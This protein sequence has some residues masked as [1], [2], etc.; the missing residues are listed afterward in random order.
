MQSIIKVFFLFSLFLFSSNLFA[1]TIAFDKFK[2]GSLDQWVGAGYT[3]YND[4][5]MYID[6]DETATKQ[7]NFGT[8]YANQE[9]SITFRFYVPDSWEKDGKYK[10]R[11]RVY[12][13]G[14]LVKSY[15]NGG[16]TKTKTILTTANAGGSITL[17]FKPDSTAN[18][19][20]AAVD[21]VKITGT[22]ISGPPVIAPTSFSLNKNSANNTTV[23]TA[24]TSP[25]A[26]AYSI[27][28]GNTD[29]IFSIDNNGL[30]KVIDNTNLTNTLATSYTLR[31][32]ASN[33]SGSD[34]GDII[35]NIVTTAII[36]TNL[37]DFSIRNP[38]RT[39]NIKGNIK[40][41][42]NSVL[43]YKVNGVCTER[44]RPNNETTLSYIKTSSG[45][46]NSSQAE[47][48]D[49]PINAK[50]LW[51]GFY[52][53]GYTNES[54]T[55]MKND[56]QNNA[57]YLIEP[58]GDRLTILPNNIDLFQWNGYTYSTYSELPQL[59]GMTGG[60]INGYWTG[61]NIKA[62]EG[63]DTSLGYFGAWTLV[64]IYEEASESLKN[65]SVFDGY[66][67]VS[68][69]STYKNIY[70]PVTGFLTPTTGNIASSLSVFAGEGDSS[71]RGDKLYVDN[72]DISHKDS[73]GTSNAFHSGTTGFN[74][75]PTLINHFGIDI[76]NYDIG[77]TGFD[78]IQHSQQSSTIHLT[79]A[80]DAYF[81][82]MV[83][84]TT[85][86]F[87]PRVCY[88]QSFLDASGA[89]LS[90]INI[91]D[92]I[93]VYT[94][95]SNM[96]KDATDGNLESADKVEITM[97]L[98]SD[99]LEYITDSTSVKNIGDAAYNST[100]KDAAGTS[101]VDIADFFSDTNTSKWR[102]GTGAT[103]VLGGLLLPNATGV[104][105]GKA[106]IKFK[107]KILKDG[108]ISVN[109]IYKVSY[110]NPQ[111][112]IRFGDE[113]PINIGVCADINTS[114]GVAGLLGAFNVVNENGGGSAYDDATNA[115][116]WLP[117]QVAGRS[118]NV[119]LLSLNNTGNALQGYTGDVDV[120]LIQTPNYASCGNDNSC[121]QTLCDNQ[122]T[123]S[124]G[125]TVTFTGEQSK[126]LSFVYTNAYQNVSFKMTYNNGAKNACSLD[127][128][129][130][131]PDRFLLSAP[132][133][134]DIEL[135]T[136]AQNYN[137]SL[138]AA[139]NTPSVSA[140]TGYTIATVDST[141][142][143]LNKTMYLK[144]G[145]I[146]AGNTL[147]GNLAFSAT[148]FS[149]TDGTASNVVGLSF[150]DVG[151]VNI[152][153]IDKTWAQVDIANSDTAQDCSMTGAYVCGGADAIFIPSS[154]S[155]SGVSLH[156]SDNTNFTYLSNDLNM[157][158]H[159]ELS[160]NAKN[161]LNA[162]TQNF[163]AS[164]WENP[165]D[166][167]FTVPVV[168]GMVINKDEVDETLN[169]SFA[170]GS[171]SILWSETNSS[172]KLMFNYNRDVNTV[173]N[174]FD[175]TGANVTLTASSLYTAPT[176]GT[177][178]TVSGTAPASLKATFLYGRTHEP[179]YRY[180]GANGVAFI[181]YESY[182]G[183]GCDKTLL[184]NGINSTTTDDPRWFINTNHLITSGSAGVVTQ[185]GANNVASTV[186]SAAPNTSVTLTYNTNRGYPY[187]A[188]MEN[189]ASSW[190]LYNKYNAGAT[191]NEF[192]IEFVNNVN[193]WAGEHETN[194][195][196]NVN[197]SSKTNR[198]TMW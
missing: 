15:S 74:V 55:T 12:I 68:S 143:D 184:P 75:N 187:K 3:Y 85:D 102:V 99:N 120:A 128:F 47:I 162:T 98:D 64:I 45:Y 35:I 179:R 122:V 181:Y 107:A 173:V 2:N 139:R 56:L 40:V 166:I 198:R 106:F 9:L 28:S 77:A 152:K 127:S 59:V 54:V 132:A 115:Q 109:N 71:Y 36:T 144:D 27:V 123:L 174:P 148:P 43:C 141:V 140:T 146:D 24:V 57:M 29:G 52:A 87:E 188:T 176:T 105:T 126:P 157:S 13:N 23:G 124:A 78:I 86:L 46:T 67:R 61:A 180:V 82:S 81:P 197:S 185:K 1:T 192:E 6:R 133:G 60:E 76:Q 158:A 172:K 63:K 189:N 34:T 145:T 51:A 94:W 156:N 93:T 195:T 4:G 14:T 73:D 90:T 104:D 37:R 161:A 121:K 112:G 165:V 42:G 11:F 80:G 118:F 92:T 194:A 25:Q 49:I 26:T 108:N 44:S 155:L 113:S 110:E 154:F 88:K 125:V 97:E 8:E 153:L 116:T 38:V 137:L 32:T 160:I 171:K 72:V 41:I 183:S 70:I 101:S 5:W 7:Y 21:Y 69:S 168:A 134:E 96:K 16:G 147:V 190:L 30:I 103:S 131:R 182:C 151:K 167:N 58:N 130:I 119:K 142:F 39:R 149:I 178:K 10:D 84:F 22:A 48:A 159:L 18:D 117:T 83:A 164:S 31:I 169:L 186:P 100:Y 170:N 150:D 19:E 66:R 138:V 129:A 53:Q 62:R 79:S 135:L 50:V 20:W 191:K 65:I 89:P 114:L 33:S 175:V 17:S 136:S 163:N 91:G 111:L 193:A 196:T 95:I 177:T